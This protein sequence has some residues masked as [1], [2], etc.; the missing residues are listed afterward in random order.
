MSGK[1]ISF[2]E[3]MIASEEHY[4]IYNFNYS[5]SFVGKS[6]KIKKCELMK[7]KKK[8]KSFF[9]SFYAKLMYVN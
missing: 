3:S 5:G 9:L 2:M 4:R 8:F 1:L 7:Q 6:K